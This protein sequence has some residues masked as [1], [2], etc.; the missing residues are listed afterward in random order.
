M[1]SGRSNEKNEKLM[2]RLYWNIVSDVRGRKGFI[3]KI[4]QGI[5]KSDDDDN[6]R[7]TFF[8]YRMFGKKLENEVERASLKVK[9]LLDE[10]R[11]TYRVVRDTTK[12]ICRAELVARGY[13]RVR[14]VRCRLLELSPPFHCMSLRRAVYSTCANVSYV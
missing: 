5:P 4:V 6:S 3:S 8:L 10:I 11:D 13:H 7:R 1:W 2:R 14:A 9:E 12:I